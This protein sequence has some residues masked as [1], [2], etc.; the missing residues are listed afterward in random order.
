[1][2]I[3]TFLTGKRIFSTFVVR[4]LKM[5]IQKGGGNGPVKP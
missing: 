4:S 2:A 3:E 5:L 1:M